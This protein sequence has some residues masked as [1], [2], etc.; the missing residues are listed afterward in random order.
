[1]PSTP[2]T[3]PR[4]SQTDPLFRACREI[5]HVGLGVADSRT[6]QWVDVNG[7]FCQMLGYTRE[8]LLARTVQDI[9]HPDDLN[10]CV[11]QL[12]ALHDGQI[13]SYQCDKRYLRKD[14]TLIWVALDVR[15]MH[16]PDGEPFVLGSVLEISERVKAEQAARDAATLLE[17][18][19]THVPAILYE[20]VL[21][22][23]GKIRLPFASHGLAELIGRSL[24]ELAEDA[25][26]F[27]SYVYPDD[28]PAFLRSIDESART[29][30]DWAYE[31]RV[32]TPN[33]QR[34]LAGASRPERRINGHI[35]WY[36]AL[37]DTTVLHDQRLALEERERELRYLFEHAAEGILVWDADSGVYTEANPS[38][39]RMLGCARDALVG[40]SP[41]TV[42]A[43]VQP[44]GVSREAYRLQ[45]MACIEE[46]RPFVA[47]WHGV[48][49]DG[50]IVP[51]ELRVTRMPV[52]GRRLYR[53]TIVDITERVREREARERLQQAIASSVNGVAM[54]DSQGV[55]TYVNPAFLTLW[56]YRSEAEI[57]G[58]SALTFW[59]APEEAQAVVVSLAKQ[60]SWT[61]ELTAQRAD[62]TTR[63]M[64]LNAS[65]I[66]DAQG[67]M[68]GMLAAFADVTETKRLEQELNQSQKLESIGRLAGGVAHDFNN[69]LTVIKASLDLAFSELPADSMARSDLLEV[70]KATDSAARLT[71]QLLAFS[72]KQ[73]IAPTTLNL[74]EVVHRVAAMLQRLLGEDIVLR[75]VTAHDLGYVRFDV[76]QAE[77]I[78]VNMAV[79][80]R[81]AMPNGGTL[82][83]ETSNTN[84]TEA[85]ARRHP[86]LRAGEYILLTVS[87]TGD[88]MSE[89]VLAHA[90]EP[91]FTTK[92]AGKGTGLGLAVIHG[93]VTQN[94][95]RVDVT[96]ALGAGTTFHV[97]LPRVLAPVDSETLTPPLPLPEGTETILLVEDDDPVRHL[98]TRLLVQQGYQVFAFDRGQAALTWLSATTDVVHLLVTDVIMPGMNGKQLAD[99]VQ[100]THPEIPVLFPSWY[101]ANVI[102][103]HGVLEPQIP[104]LPKP[105]SARELVTRVR[106]VL[107]AGR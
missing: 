64:E 95:G 26:T 102:A 105:F 16:T 19:S 5:P 33:G 68:V 96:S 13:G 23:S 67:L 104:F 31:F 55:L 34:W 39:E 1:M 35:H 92:S 20:F 18:I 49:A 62:G 100:V 94:G 66:R 2:P 10:A 73:V 79:N 9:T 78:L 74:N 84:I 60:G 28:V 75:T 50:H 72:R 17:R 89:E 15:T 103:Q 53:G 43:H 57:L 87:D 85:Y 22:P 82:T 106:E 42:S 76:G 25:N 98:M 30:S 21:E 47:E 4:L 29:L 93:A 54:S 46:G 45:A 52:A 63:I 32:L 107:D 11:T 36:G 3:V 37:T 90:F 24:N 101:T 51:C 58:R 14:G 71:Q 8:E 61:G 44:N 97:Y 86:G 12:Q 80:A 59:R 83:L 27:V 88:G 70:S 91:F 99:E 7:T 38:A 40:Q 41:M 69:L 48:H 6:G 81:D 77:Q 65:A 56:G